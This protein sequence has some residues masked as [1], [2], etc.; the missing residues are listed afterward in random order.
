LSGSADRLEEGDGRSMNVCRDHHWVTHTAEAGGGRPRTRG[1][2]P[3]RG[4][5]HLTVRGSPT[6]WSNP[7]LRV[8]PAGG[9]QAVCATTGR[10]LVHRVFVKPQGAGDCRA[11]AR[12]GRAHR[13]HHRLPCPLGISPVCMKLEAG[14]SGE[15]S[16]GHGPSWMPARP[17]HCVH[18]AGDRACRPQMV[19]QQG[20]KGRAVARSSSSPSPARAGQI[21][22]ELELA[23]GLGQRGQGG[24]AGLLAPWGEVDT[25]ERP[26]A[27]RSSTMDSPASGPSAMPDGNGPIQLDHRRAGQPAHSS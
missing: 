19:A 9:G 22:R 2:T 26:L 11:E 8:V 6:R 10:I 7:C 24:T 25:G 15:E 18:P 23:A 12:R 4:Q 17:C 3:L 13:R 5:A 21:G 16:S 27:R 1:G 14:G 20:F